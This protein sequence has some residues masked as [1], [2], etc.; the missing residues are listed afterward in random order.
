MVGRTKGENCGK[1]FVNCKTFY[2]RLKISF[3]RMSTYYFTYSSYFLSTY[4][5]PGIA[6]IAEGY[7]SE[8]SPFFHGA[9]RSRGWQD[10]KRPCKHKHHGIITVMCAMRGLS[11]GAERVW[12]Q[13]PAR[14]RVSGPRLWAASPT[15]PGLIFPH[16]LVCPDC[17]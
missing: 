2:K 1:C 12:S 8:H 11:Q 13:E 16:R 9:Y 15:S 10:I 6:L 7:R 3:R 5:V 17:G 4:C 14:P